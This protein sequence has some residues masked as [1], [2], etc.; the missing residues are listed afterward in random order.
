[1]DDVIRGAALLGA[2]GGGSPENAAEIADDAFGDVERVELVGPTEVPDETRAV[3]TGGMGSPEQSK[4]PQA[5]EELF[6]VERL[7]ATLDEEFGFLLPFEIGAGNVARPFRAAAATG[8]PVVDGDGAGRAV[9]E[10]QMATYNLAGISIAPFALS[11]AD[12]NAAVLYPNDTNAG[13]RMS[14]ALTVEFGGSAGFA[15]YPMD[16]RR[17]QETV[18][19]GTVSKARAVGETLRTAHV[20]GDDPVRAVVE[21]LD[22]ALLAR[23]TVATVATETRDGFDFAEVTLRDT[24]TGGEVRVGVKNENM[25]AWRDDELLAVAPDLICWVTPDGAALTNVDV[26]AGTD[27]A[28]VGAPAPAELRTGAAIALFEPILEALGHDGGYVSLAELRGA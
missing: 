26:E 7:E 3:V 19:A 13:E 21:H 17:V 24:A 15:C 5:R 10:L 2:G 11:A 20:A 23:G 18:V 25:V 9:P 8:R 22:G 28:L 6:A 27:V 16:G 1:M 4:G 14:R 12:R